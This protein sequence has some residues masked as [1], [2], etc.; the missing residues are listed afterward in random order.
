MLLY[1]LLYSESIGAN[2][3]YLLL[4]EF[5][6]HIVSHKRGFFPFNLSFLGHELKYIEQG[7]VIIAQPKKMR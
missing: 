1:T 2:N 4:T 6:G 3:E 7:G 5:D